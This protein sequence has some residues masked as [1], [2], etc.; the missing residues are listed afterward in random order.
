M[1]VTARVLAV[2]MVAAFACGCSASEQVELTQERRATADGDGDGTYDVVA[3][4]EHQRQAVCSNLEPLAEAVLGDITGDELDTNGCSYM[5]AS[6][7]P[8]AFVGVA[9]FMG[10]R[11]VLDQMTEDFYELG[12]DVTRVSDRSGST[13]NPWVPVPDGAVSVHIDCGSAVNY[14]LIIQNGRAFDPDY[15]RLAETVLCD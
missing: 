5:T 10:E 1:T 2:V 9:G 8:S 13:S 4:P 3:W 6:R 15:V 14:D 11:R 7:R 12:Q